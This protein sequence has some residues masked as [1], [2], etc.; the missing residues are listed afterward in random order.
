MRSFT[1]AAAFAALAVANPLPQEIDW[2]AVDALTPI[3]TVTIPVV[4]VSAQA[5]TVSYEPSAA[6]TSVAA[7]VNASGVS[8]ASAGLKARAAVTCKPQPTGAGPVPTPDTPEGF[9][10]YSDFSA[11][12]DSAKTPSGYYNTFTNLQAS[13]NAYG[14]VSASLHCNIILLADQRADTWDTLC[15]ASTR[16]RPV[17]ISAMP[18]RAVLPSTSTSSAILLSTVR[19]PTTI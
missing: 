7:E 19:V 2:A 11:T 16:L 9:L 14:Y 13:N 12:A 1:V 10:A 8:S 15:S 6:A 4:D 17:L 3:P 18:S 5:S